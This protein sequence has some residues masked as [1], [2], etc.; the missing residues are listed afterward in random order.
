MADHRNIDEAFHQLARDI[1]VRVPRP[2]PL[3]LARRATRRRLR[4][5]VL[6]AT[7]AIATVIL[8]GAALVQGFSAADDSA[9][10]PPTT[11]DTTAPTPDDPAVPS[12]RCARPE[13]ST[14][15]LARGIQLTWSSSFSCDRAPAEGRFRL[16]IHLAT[17]TNG[18]GALSLDMMQPMR[19][20]PR[21]VEYGAQVGAATQL[22]LVLDD[23]GGAADLVVRGT[24]ELE[25]R[26][27]D[28]RA[29]LRLRLVGHVVSS[30]AGFEVDVVV[31]L[32]PSGTLEKDPDQFHA[33][34]P[35]KSTN[36]TPDQTAPPRSDR[37][38][39]T[40]SRPDADRMRRWARCL[41]KHSTV[42]DWADMTFDPLAECGRRP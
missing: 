27:E 1:G 11:A 30:G 12:V 31:R 34:K 17:T 23:G 9:P 15:E 32:R 18:R 26:T 22:P 20:R 33:H 2:S 39:D 42:E 29:T 14:D 35:S 40:A 41:A 36:G 10:R 7:T 21:S 6:A 25:T 13:R 3:T 19:P 8:G 24:Y 28:E 5:I 37:Q 16:T 38:P 4:Q